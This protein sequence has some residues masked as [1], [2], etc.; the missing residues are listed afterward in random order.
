[1]DMDTQTVSAGTVTTLYVS[2]VPL[3]ILISYL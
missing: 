2:L 3:I 1:M